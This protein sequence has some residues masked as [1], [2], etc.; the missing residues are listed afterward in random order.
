MV[1]R[2]A[3]CRA[4]PWPF[5]FTHRPHSFCCV[6]VTSFDY[7]VPLIS[8][9]FCFLLL[10]HSISKFLIAM[11]VQAASEQACTQVMRD[12]THVVE[13]RRDT[14]CLRW[15]TWLDPTATPIVVGWTCI[16]PATLFAILMDEGKKEGVF[17]NLPH[18]ISKIG[19]W[20][21]C[22]KRTP[23]LCRTSLQ[24]RAIGLKE[25]H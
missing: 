23:G 11:T 10:L 3:R 8:E 1:R 21:R 20:N 13:L 14:A 2:Y 18:W 4:S 16:A 5:F 15:T 12:A 19:I 9:M 25:G 22:V 6:D 7:H 17:T 24:F